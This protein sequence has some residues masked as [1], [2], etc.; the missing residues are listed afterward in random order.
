MLRFLL[1]LPVYVV[2]PIAGRL[3]TRS[4]TVRTLAALFISLVAG[5]IS[6]MVMETGPI[7]PAPTPLAAVDPDLDGFGKVIYNKYVDFERLKWRNVVVH[8]SAGGRADIARRCHF[9][10]D[11]NPS[12]G[13]AAVTA[14]ELWKRQ[15]VGH[16]VYVPGQDFAAIS[17]GVCLVGDFSR[18]SPPRSQ[19]EAMISLV[20]ALQ[21]EFGVQ[22]DQVYLHSD[23]VPN[24]SS[25]GAAFPQRDFSRRL[26]HP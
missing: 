17:V 16:H 19:Y 1:N 4:R 18:Q 2:Q 22:P 8:S 15:A 7:Q 3:M 20:R 9:L 6:L 21:R 5:T 13:R 11:V 25:P 24:S 10:V 12:T 26:L 14:T 23:L